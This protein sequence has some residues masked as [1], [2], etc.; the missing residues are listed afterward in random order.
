MFQVTQPADDLNL[1]TIDEL[2]VAVGLDADDA[3]QDAKLETLGKRVSAMIAASC[4]VAKDGV[5][6][7]TLLLEGCEDSYRLKCGQQAIYL[8]RRPVQQMVSV[9]VNGTTMAQ[10]VD[11]EVDPA[12]GKLVRLCGDQETWWQAGRIVV[13]YDAGYETVPDDLKAIAAQLAGG[14][15]ADDGVDPLEKRISIPGVMDVERWVDS[16]AD[17]Q[18]PADILNALTVAGYVNRDMVY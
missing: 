9:T 8:S 17:P 3:S 18:M 14:Y 1:L 4:R 6:P 15:W 5:N 12:A 13:E 10:D 11:Y 7:P 2:R 16:S